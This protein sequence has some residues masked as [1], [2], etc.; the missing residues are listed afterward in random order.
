MPTGLSVQ[1]QQDFQTVF[2]DMPQNGPPG[3]E[4]LAYS[5]TYGNSFFL[6]FDTFYLDPARGLADRGP[7]HPTGT[8]RLGR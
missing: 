6:I 1:Q 4:S 7:P 3:Y 8:I 2:S 5:F